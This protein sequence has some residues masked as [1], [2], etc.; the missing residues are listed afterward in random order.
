MIKF[1]KNKKKSVI[2]GHDLQRIARI[3]NVKRLLKAI[4]HRELQT[5]SAVTHIMCNTVLKK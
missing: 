2:T 4:R 3:L 1:A 5:L